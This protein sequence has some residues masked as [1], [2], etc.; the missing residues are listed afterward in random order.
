VH[1]ACAFSLGSTD[2]SPRIMVCVLLRTKNEAFNLSMINMC[3]SQSKGLSIDHV[4]CAS[5]RFLCTSLGLWPLP[6]LCMCALVYK[7]TFYHMFVHIIVSR[8]LNY[9]TSSSS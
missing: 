7:A 5:T 9:G 6:L 3:L 8:L 4:Q 2:S 1:V